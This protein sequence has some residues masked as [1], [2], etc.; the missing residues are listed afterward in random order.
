MEDSYTPPPPPLPQG[1]GGSKDPILVLVL[2]LL[3]AGVGSIVLGQK[4]K[5]IVGIVIWLVAIPVT[6]GTLSLAVGIVLAIDAYL[7]AQPL[8]AGYPIGDGT[9]FNGHL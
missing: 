6:C 5:G 4:V 8:R 7:Q 9:F 1:G 3:V 2:N